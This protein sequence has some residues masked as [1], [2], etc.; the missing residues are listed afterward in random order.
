VHG[1]KE[2]DGSSRDDHDD[3]EDSHD[4]LHN[5]VHETSLVMDEVPRAHKISH[6]LIKEVRLG[7]VR[8]RGR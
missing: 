7:N 5:P 6:A 1:S 2:N 4:P 3:N 8:E